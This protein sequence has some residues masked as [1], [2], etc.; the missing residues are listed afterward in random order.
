MKPEFEKLKDTGMCAHGNFKDSCAV[1]QKENKQTDEKLDSQEMNAP[2]TENNRKN[3]ENK[4]AISSEAERYINEIQE[5]IDELEKMLEKYNSMEQSGNNN[6]IANLGA[7]VWER[8]HWVK[9]SWDDNFKHLRQT[10]DNLS[11][12]E[13]WNQIS[14]ALSERMSQISEASITYDPQEKENYSNPLEDYEKRDIEK[15]LALSKE[16]LGIVKSIFN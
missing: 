6:A 8:L 11:R 5:N 12:S 14:S 4:D 10:A 9:N 13:Q 16:S 7:E 1:C 3:T 15:A 2:E